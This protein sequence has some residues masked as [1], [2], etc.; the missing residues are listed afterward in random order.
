MHT[1]KAVKIYSPFFIIVQQKKNQVDGSLK[2]FISCFDNSDM[3][4]QGNKDIETVL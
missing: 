4:V 2:R 3:H 1:R